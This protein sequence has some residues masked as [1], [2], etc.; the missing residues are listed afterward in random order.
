M[1]PTTRIA[2][3]IKLLCLFVATAGGSAF[4]Q[5]YAFHT[6]A[7]EAG[8]GS[9]DG[10]LSAARFRRPQGVAAD[11]QG[12]VYVADTRNSTIRKIAPDGIVTTLAGLAGT[13]LSA[14]GTLNADGIG[15][16]ARFSSPVGVAVDGSGHVFVADSINM[17]RRISADGVVTTLAGANAVSGWVDGV[18]AEAQFWSPQSLAVD[19]SG[20]VF[21]AD[22]ANNA[23]R[24]I[25]TNGVVT[26]LAGGKS[27]DGQAISD[28]SVD[29][30]G[31]AARFWFP[32]GVA[33]DAH[34]N[35]F[36]ADTLNNTIRKITAGGVVT[37]LAGM[38][39]S[40]GSA[41]SADGAGRT[42][43]FDHPI[44]IAVDGGG[45]LFVADTRNHTI[46][47]IGADG[48][49]TTLAGSPGNS[50][51]A[52]GTGSAARFNRP[53][54]LAHDVAG[55]LL[56]AD[57]DNNTIR[58]ISAAGVVT[59]L[60]G[61]ASSSGSADGTGHDARFQAP[62]GV[63]VD[64]SGGRVLVADTLNHT[65]RTI[66]A[67]GV[68]ATLAGTA[69]L[70]GSA[71]GLG[72]AARFSSPAGVAVD[73]SGTVFV[74]DAGNFTIRQI[75]VSG[76]VTTLAGAAGVAGNVDGAGGAAR[77]SHPHGVAVDLGGNVYVADLRTIRK[78]T[79]GG[80]VTTLAGSPIMDSIY[81][82]H[83]DG[84]PNVARFTNI[85]G[86]A[87]DADGNLFV[88]DVHTI[89]RISPEGF[90]TTLAGIF[91]PA[92]R[93]NVSGGSADGVGSAARFSGPL[94][95]AVDR[96]GNVFVADSGNSTIRR[97]SAAG[98]V[99]TLARGTRPGDHAD[100]TGGGARFNAPAGVAVDDRGNL[101]IADTGNHT[102]RQGVT[103]AN[104]TRLINFSILS[105]LAGGETMT[106]G[107]IIGGA[108]TNG[109]KPLLAR[110]A[111]PSLAPFGVTGRLDD[112]KFEF[113]AG[114]EKVNE[115]DNW[116]GAANLGEAFAEVGAFPFAGPTSRDAARHLSAVAAGNHTVRVSGSGSAGGTVLAELYDA[117]PASALTSVTPRLLN[118][119]VL[120]NVGSGLTAGFVLDGQGMK[121]VLIR[122]VGPSLAV[123]G[124]S[125]TLADPRLELFD[126]QS[127]RIAA[128]DN[129][130]DAGALA[131][132]A[133]A[134]TF[135]QVGAFALA[136]PMAK[137][138]ALLIT[139]GPGNYTVQVRSA[140]TTTGVALV[141]VYEV[142]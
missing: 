83:V 54:G 26:T 48:V 113:F 139:L 114:T 29:G 43:R 110:A 125:G 39:G 86:I 136:A 117:T 74:A 84:P 68:V 58:K 71:D 21:I 42:A 112:P 70:A 124:V 129:W 102:I 22:T 15:R 66:S 59:T 97:I 137:D 138:A 133:L 23:I 77:F 82:D 92:I 72:A 31:S 103:P 7:G 53:M 50:G 51:S 73:G 13:I 89:R 76:L 47:K 107:T 109:T 94:G 85:R 95:V 118:V 120:K 130:G 2:V 132:A 142:P 90:V 115:N 91:L 62:E 56:V 93:G 11:A 81:G 67:T 80:V 27:A 17:I 4:A 1:I 128:N 24:K 33:V 44:G 87:V 63:A 57:S 9:A 14:A 25:D 41:G 88:S 134:A 122:A 8:Y 36:V 104:P 127:R 126:G 79:A 123:F 37:T 105:D 38:A 16:A 141:E 40:S 99:T 119:S 140:D 55:N 5:T 121:T 69:G 65:I 96:G 108:G 52:D 111:G 49:V 100:G 135:T 46:R 98:I 61:A 116:G 101:F 30:T 34:G 131:T 60:T 78:I 106:V 10:L 32:S 64:G 19:A 3:L 35:V 12:N 28:G 20:N 45:T 75:T 18:G 6:L